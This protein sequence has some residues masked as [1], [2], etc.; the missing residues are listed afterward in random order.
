M[1]TQTT[2]AR[3]SAISCLPVDVLSAIFVW[4]SEPESEPTLRY[5]CSDTVDWDWVDLARP[6]WFPLTQ[7]YTHWREVALDTPEL[8]RHMDAG[9]SLRP[10]ELGLLRSRNRMVEVGV[11]EWRTAEKAILL[12]LPHVHR[13][14]KLSLH[15][16][17]DEDASI[18][19]IEAVTKKVCL[20]DFPALEELCINID[21][22][23]SDDEYAWLIPLRPACFPAL[24]LVRLRWA[25]LPWDSALLEQL[26]VLHMEEVALDRG[27]RLSLD[28]FLA[29]LERCQSLEELRLFW[30][31]PV[32]FPNQNAVPD[33]DRIVI[34]P[35][36]RFVHLG[37]D[38]VWTRPSE[39]YQ[40]LKHM[41][42]PPQA[43]LNVVVDY[44]FDQWDLNADARTLLEVIPQDPDSL[45]ILKEA[46]SLR[47]SAC[48]PPFPATYYLVTTDG[49]VS[50]DLT[51]KPNW[52][53][54]QNAWTFN[55]DDQLAAFCTIF[56]HTRS[57]TTLSIATDLY[58]VAGLK[59][60][61]RALGELSVIK[62]EYTS[63]DA[64]EQLLCALTTPVAADSPLGPPVV[65]KLRTLRIKT[66]PWG[67]DLLP[68]ID[69]CLE[70]R[71]NRGTELSRL[72]LEA[73]GRPVD[74]E[75]GT[76]LELEHTMQIVSLQMQVNGSVE[77]VDVLAPA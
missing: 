38:P 70:W 68:T 36:L 18:E 71:A 51:L 40:L 11:H 4:T 74:E 3:S 16:L 5:D 26:R 7:V 34:L 31:F 72:H 50:L 25:Y 60:A 12:L 75:G 21:Y 65:P 2:R 47:L 41:R 24:R 76:D 59:A 43:S 77:F 62:A 19:V 73:Y 20:T 28:A 32:H 22:E 9:P 17:P 35:K 58:T 37:W 23:P 49:G 45:P 56:A 8:W 48:E 1:D 6:A 55:V 13:L 33:S 52:V 46:T 15:L 53:I 27:D 63:A 39:I 69:R 67:P 29:T 44:C 10:L 61:F 14:R 30:A 66:L 57:L 54:H 42:L 64:L